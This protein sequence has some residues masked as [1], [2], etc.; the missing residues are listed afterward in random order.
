MIIM[1]DGTV[2]QTKELAE[3]MNLNYP[4]L[5]DSQHVVFDR[6]NPEIK[7]PSTI[8]FKYGIIIATP[9]LSKNINNIDRKTSNI[10]LV[11]S[12]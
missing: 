2:E 5:L 3:D 7:L 6:W 10:Y 1:Y 9:K 11:L 12:W 8:I 4:I